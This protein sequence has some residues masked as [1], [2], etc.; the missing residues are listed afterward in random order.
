[1]HELRE[2]VQDRGVQA[3]DA[4]VDEAGVTQLSQPYIVTDQV[5]RDP[6]KAISELVVRRFR[7]PAD[8]PTAPAAAGAKK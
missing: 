6:D 1:M 8:A 3:F 7:A 2:A 5:A 4:Q